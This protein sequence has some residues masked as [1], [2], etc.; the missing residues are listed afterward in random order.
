VN[1]QGARAGR[2]G[3]GAGAGAGAA[4][5][6]GAGAAATTTGAVIG[7]AAGSIVSQVVAIAI[8]QQD[9]FSWK[10]VAAAALSGGLAPGV[11]SATSGWGAAATAAVNN[12]VSQG[13]NIALGLQE[14]FSW[15]AVAASAV[16]A[17]IARQVAPKVAG[18]ISR[19]F[20]SKA[21]GE[22]A[23]RLAGGLVQQ[24]ASVAFNGGRIDYANLV[25]DAFGNA[26]GNSIVS[27]MTPKPIGVTAEQFA[28]VAAEMDARTNGLMERTGSQA[29]ADAGRTLD[30]MEFEHRL[31]ERIQLSAQAMNDKLDMQIQASVK[32]PPQIRFE[33]ETNEMTAAQARGLAYFD[34]QLA[35]SLNGP[36]GVVPMAGG[37]LA[38]MDHSSYVAPGFVASA[39]YSAAAEAENGNNSLGTRAINLGLAVATAPLALAEEAGR[40]ILNIPYGAQRV[41]Q[42]LAIV[43]LSSDRDTQIL[44]GLDAVS[45]GAQAFTAAGSVVPIGQAAN[46]F[47]AANLAPLQSAESFAAARATYAPNQPGLRT[48]TVISAERAEGYLIENG[49]SPA[50]A[51]D[52][53]ASFDGPITARIARP[54]EAGYRYTDIADSQGNFLTQSEFAT[55]P[56]AVSGLYLRPEYQNNATLRQ[57]VTATGRSIVLE[58]AVRNGGPGV[59]QTVVINRNTFNYGTGVG[60]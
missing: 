46:A 35:R 8:G 5:G 28:E 10:G 43:N 29:Y 14:R 38:E 53:V 17:P 41:G 1:V 30:Q 45:F 25:A 39:Y 9:K 51:K 37:A 33:S 27:G 22:F 3:A 26:L 32:A 12:V 48:S 52:Y 23:G 40:A 21:A 57:T 18:A 54:G 6:A 2:S 55:P 59:Q 42:D 24:V 13:V 50:R 47:G 56:D 58:G 11:S 15:A 60:Y 16:A 20:S 19:E 31:D 4:A 7:A 34:K 44:A 36:S 49:F